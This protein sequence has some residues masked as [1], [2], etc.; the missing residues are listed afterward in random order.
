MTVLIG[1]L[2]SDGVVIGSDSAATFTAGNLRT[3][4]QPCKKI[5]VI[6][7]NILVRGLGLLAKDKD[8]TQW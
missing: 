8:S 6:K 2:C 1:V 4:E 7:N 5:H 3:I